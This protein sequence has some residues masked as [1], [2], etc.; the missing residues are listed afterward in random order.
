MGDG[1]FTMIWVF[2]MDLAH[3]I[4]LALV[5]ISILVPVIGFWQMFRRQE[6][7]EAIDAAVFLAQRQL[8]DYI[9]RSKSP[10]P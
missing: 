6:R 8:E 9:K 3:I 2:Q 7:D 5:T 4:V 10:S 1:G